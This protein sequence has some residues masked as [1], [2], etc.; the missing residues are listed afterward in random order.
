MPD[1]ERELESDDPD[2]DASESI[3]SKSNDWPVG[4]LAQD[5]ISNQPDPV[6]TRRPNNGTGTRQRHTSRSKFDESGTVWKSIQ[7]WTLMTLFD[8]IGEPKVVG[9]LTLGGQGS[10]V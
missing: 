3:L 2:Y 4:E 7:V 10:K 8:T 9:N 6:R 5:N 1:S